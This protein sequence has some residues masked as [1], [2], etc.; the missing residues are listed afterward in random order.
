MLETVTVEGGNEGDTVL[1][2]VGEDALVA[3]TVGSGSGGSSAYAVDY[4]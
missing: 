1:V 3:V 2:N 4:S